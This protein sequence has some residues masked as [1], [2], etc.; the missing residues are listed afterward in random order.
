MQRKTVYIA[1]GETRLVENQWAAECEKRGATIVSSTW[2][3]TPALGAESLT[4]TLATVLI[5]ASCDGCLTNTVVLSNGET[6]EIERLVR[7]ER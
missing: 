4:G 7:L 6:L 3:G 1:D 2:A 5:S